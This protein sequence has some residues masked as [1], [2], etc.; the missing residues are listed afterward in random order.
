MNDSIDKVNA[1]KSVTQYNVKL[2]RL[3]LRLMDE[4]FKFFFT[5]KSSD[6]FFLVMLLLHWFT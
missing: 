5:K 3:R 1:M 6:Y 4:D 2:I